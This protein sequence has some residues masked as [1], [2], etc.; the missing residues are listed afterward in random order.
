MSHR[1]LHPP[2]FTGRASHRPGGIFSRTGA[3]WVAA[4]SLA[5]AF[6]ST[7]SATTQDPATVTPSGEPPAVQDPAVH[8]P[9]L[10]DPALQDP[11][12]QDPALQV[13]AV[14]APAG[15]RAHTYEIDVRLDADS[16]ILEGTAQVTIRNQGDS[17]LDRC[18]FRLIPNAWSRTDTRW[19]K[20]AGRAKDIRERGVEGAGFMEIQAVTDAAGAS[21]DDHAIIDE[22]LMRI[23]LPAGIDPGA[24]TTL[25][26]QFR[27][28]L[29][30]I[31]A[32]MGKVGSHV[33]AMQWYPL[34]TKLGP[35]GQY[36]ETPFREPSEFFADF[37]DY[38]VAITV[39]APYVIGATGVLSGSNA[40][41]GAGT[42][43]DTY[44]ANGVIDFAWCA[45]PNF[46]V[47]TETSRRGVE[48]RL[49]AQPFMAPKAELT[50][51]A[52]RFAMDRLDAWIF[53]YPYER[54]VIDVM[55]HGIRGGMEYP[56]LFTIG[57]RAP[58]PFAWISERSE[59]PSS[60]TIHE[61]THQY[62][63]GMIATNEID[64]AWLDEGLTTYLTAKI[65][66]EFWTD[67]NGGAPPPRRGLPVVAAERVYMELLGGDHVLAEALG[68]PVS[69]F[70]N[71]RASLLG[72][73]PPDVVAGGSRNARFLP[74]KDSYGPYAS[75][76]DLKSPSYDALRTGDGNAYGS[77][78][79]SKPTLMLR[80]LEGMVGWDRTREFLGEHGRRH[81]FQHPTS[82]EFLAVASDVLGDD[83][84]AFLTSC[85]ETNATVDWS[86]AAVR[87]R[88][89]VGVGFS[90]QGKPGDPIV[91]EFPEGTHHEGA[92][93]RVRD[94][95]TPAAILAARSADD[96]GAAISG[97][98]EPQFEADVWVHNH[99]SLQVPVEVELRFAD[100]R[101][102]R[103]ELDGKRASYRIEIPAGSARLI[104]AEVDPYRRVALDLDVSNNSRL[105]R[106]DADPVRVIGAFHQFWI[107]SLISIIGWSA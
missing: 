40:D 78:A 68:H 93:D 90:R 67:R 56:M 26:L 72:F 36:L 91:S 17:P 22:T 48:I 44:V 65:A 61:Y 6:G 27:T 87:V 35:D 94:A 75:S 97:E 21:L 10:H 95:M 12:L 4:V 105:A 13:P 1:E 41:E 8:D 92:L 50:L 52:A 77:T 39:P 9:A 73:L 70:L 106:R 88:P 24:E 84:H 96:D 33:N 102:E 79:Y 23:S 51:S 80:T 7:A 34:L 18:V 59:D 74:R 54:L 2:R 60:V 5:A 28:R 62:F 81:A 89:V 29:P 66:E 55:P 38:R 58:E 57:A 32:R 103:K 86:V 11:A 85:I 104:S 16:M 64:E 71:D 76:S 98:G 20:D 82:D 47:H 43:T 100:G 15:P 99:G 30:E 14:F 31:V 3:A 101:V 42:R 37:S 25:T 49:L 45:S 83:A 53:P 69:P 63:Q 19:V 107:Q 46:E